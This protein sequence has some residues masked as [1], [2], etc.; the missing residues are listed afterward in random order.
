M[1]RILK[2]SGWLVALL[3]LIGSACSDDVA[4]VEEEPLPPEYEVTG[5]YT[6]EE[7]FCM[8]GEKRIYGLL[9]KPVGQAPQFPAVILSHSAYLTHAAMQSY[10]VALAQ[11]GYVAYCFD[12]CGGSTDS[13]SDGSP[14]EMT[15][16]TEVEDLEAVLTTVRQLDCVDAGRVCLLGTSQGGVVSALV[17]E[18]RAEQ[19]RG[20]LLFYP[21]FNIPE[22][23]N[24][25]AG[26]ASGS[27]AAY[28]ESLK[29]YDVFEHIGTFDKEV[30]ILH[31]SN[32][33]IVNVSYSRRAAALYLHAE[34]VVIEGAT[35]GFN[36]DNL[37]GFGALLGAGANC[38]GIV[39]EHVFAFL[40]SVSARSPQ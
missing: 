35:H 2:K 21:A 28:I 25:F 5:E 13:L 40:S 29:G 17:A 6:C 19:V 22:L 33:F 9:Y 20:L 14:S 7:L 34:L 32:D 30:L 31:G 24:L 12:F 11:Q 10:C 27:N 23:A 3:F 37:G 16:F 15:L 1:E 38:D 4:V 18:A 26:M 36:E 8:N 39:L